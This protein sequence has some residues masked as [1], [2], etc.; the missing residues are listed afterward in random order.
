MGSYPKAIQLKD[1]LLHLGRGQA[2]AY[3]DGE[4]NVYAINQKCVR[5]GAVSI[6]Y[7]RPHDPRK[8]LKDSSVL[9]DGDV[10]INSTGTGTIGRIG[11]WHEQRH[12]GDSFFADSHVTIARPD[13][14]IANPKFLASIL[15]SDEYQAI[16]ETHCFSGS[17]NQVELNKKALGDLSVYL[18]D[19]SSQAVVAEILSTVD[20][21]IEQ[22]EAIIAKQQR[23]KTGLMQDLLTKGI[24][25]DG[26][27][28]SEETHEFKA[29]PLG[30]IPSAWAT[31]VSLSA[32][33][34]FITSGSRG[35][36]QYYSSEGARFIRIGNMVRNNINLDIHDNIYVEPPKRS[37]GKRTSL[38]ADD[39]LISI[40]AD[41][42]IVSVVPNSFGE[43]Y[44]NQHIALV[45]LKSDMVNSRFAGWFLAS[46][47]GQQQIVKLNESGAKAGLNLPT[48]GS[49]LLP[50]PQQSEQ[51]RIAKILDSSV[52]AIN[53]TICQLSKLQSL[54]AA[55]MQD[56]LTGDVSVANLLD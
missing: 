52:E 13:K 33:S 23:I 5:D 16:I 9:Q 30:R 47:L 32:C 26:N 29:S 41:L 6:E 39:M 50:L 14:E 15:Q 37:E 20:Q 21:A 55:L 10:C 2:P 27:I 51:Q 17:T 12:N 24:D 38:R 45:R 36:A 11:L 28:R 19:K 34:Q 25:K 54:K 56:L 3:Y 8:K 35:W 31:P 48:V 49:L 4:S 18:L 43:S 1:C 44:I 7:A 46:F 42:G 53:F 22:T 40:T